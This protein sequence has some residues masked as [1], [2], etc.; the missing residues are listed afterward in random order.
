MKVRQ[1][2]QDEVVFNDE[3][4]IQ[5]ILWGSV[6]GRMHSGESRLYKMIARYN[7]GV[8]FGAKHLDNGRSSDIE[9]WNVCICD[10]EIASMPKQTFQELWL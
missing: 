8:I 2:K 5:I 10:V 4:N 3:S 6:E 1:V 9:C 7:E